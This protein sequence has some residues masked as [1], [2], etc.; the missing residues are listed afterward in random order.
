MRPCAGNCFDELASDGE[1]APSII[2]ILP[3]C[4][5]PILRYEGSLAAPQCTEGVQ[6]NI[7]TMPAHA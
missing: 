3:I 4:C 1:T 6:H 7:I 2:A 5:R